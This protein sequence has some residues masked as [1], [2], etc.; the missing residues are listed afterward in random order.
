MQLLSPG[1]TCPTFSLPLPS[2]TLSLP[3]F[4]S[5]SCSLSFSFCPP[6][7]A[8]AQLH[9]PGWVQWSM[10]ASLWDL[11]PSAPQ[12]TALALWF[13]SM[14]LAAT[15]AVLSGRCCLVALIFRGIG[16]CARSYTKE[17]VWTIHP[18]GSPSSAPSLLPFCCIMKVLGSIGPVFP[19]REAVSNGREGMSSLNLS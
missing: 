1:L 12:D 18:D 16:P 8:S 6:C 15:E 17:Q 2:A 5:P 7:T 14:V 4:L 3:L 13:P 10:Q 9:G 19:H 11:Q